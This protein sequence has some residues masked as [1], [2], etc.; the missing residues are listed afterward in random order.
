MAPIFPKESKPVPRTSY[1]SGSQ[2]DL[3][4]ACS[5]IVSGCQ[6]LM[7]TVLRVP[8]ICSGFLF[9]K[10]LLLSYQ[11]SVEYLLGMRQL[12]CV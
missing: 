1:V 3:E 9:A 10:R 5:I 11:G 8:R 12:M 6:W 2:F 4:G 7:H